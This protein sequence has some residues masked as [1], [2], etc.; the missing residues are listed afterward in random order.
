MT[1]LERYENEAYECAAELI[2]RADH[3]FTGEESRVAKFVADWLT[4]RLK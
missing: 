3:A 1:E 2:E 4:R